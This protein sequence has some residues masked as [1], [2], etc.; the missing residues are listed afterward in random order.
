MRPLQDYQNITGSLYKLPW[1]MTTRGHKQWN[2]A[3]MLT[4]FGTFVREAASTLERRNRGSPDDVWLRSPLYPEYYL[5]TF[6]YQ[7]QPHRPFIRRFT[8]L[9]TVN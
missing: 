7:V 9:G 2:P 3:A 6:H 5:N 4:A 8:G 1:D